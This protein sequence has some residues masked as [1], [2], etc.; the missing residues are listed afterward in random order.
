MQLDDENTAS[1]TN[2]SASASASITVPVSNDE[3][4]HKFATV[5]LN[6]QFSSFIFFFKERVYLHL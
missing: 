5:L 1:N 2:E 4:K 3:G 6:I